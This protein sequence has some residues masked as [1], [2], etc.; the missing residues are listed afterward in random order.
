MLR[1]ATADRELGPLER[2]LLESLWRQ[3]GEASVRDVARRYPE[4]AYTTL[5]TTLDRLHR[6]GVLARRREGRAYLYKP[7]LTRDE[8]ER[9]RAERAVGALLEN[10]AGPALAPALSFFVDAVSERDAALLDELELLIRARRR[11]RR[12]RQ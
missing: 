5:M 4:L 11:E 3:G 1:H 12:G 7:R 6:K 9:R 8:F 2:R 10:A